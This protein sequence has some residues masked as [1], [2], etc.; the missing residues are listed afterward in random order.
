MAQ[1][2]DF[3][4]ISTRFRTPGI[5]AALGDVGVRKPADLLATYVTDHTGLVAYTADALPV[6][7]DRPRIEYSNW[8]RRREI[9]RVL[10]K[11]LELREPPPVVAS[12]EEKARIEIS[13]R[14]LVDF[15]E[16]SLLALTGDRE[17]WTAKLQAFSRNAEPNPYYDWF[18][19]G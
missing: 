15:Y 17:A 14:R 1:P 19:G 5:A 2:L 6:T 18:F 10:P 4:T 16:I 8:V 9:T 12:P 3:S 7:D 13:H 11:L